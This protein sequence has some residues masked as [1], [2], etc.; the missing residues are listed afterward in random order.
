M[1]IRN[2]SFYPMIWMGF[3]DV[4][5][6]KVLLLLVF[7]SAKGIEQHLHVGLITRRKLELVGFYELDSCPAVSNLGL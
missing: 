7:F 1:K 3:C 5:T 6:N 2:S 4:A